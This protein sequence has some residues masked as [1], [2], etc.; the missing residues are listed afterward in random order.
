[1]YSICIFISTIPDIAAIIYFSN[2]SSMQAGLCYQE[3]LECGQQLS[4]LSAV[5]TKQI[6]ISINWVLPLTED[7]GVCAAPGYIYSVV[8]L[9]GDNS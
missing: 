3:D 6:D 7:G 5:T 1:M 2:L 9:S 4:L 8:S